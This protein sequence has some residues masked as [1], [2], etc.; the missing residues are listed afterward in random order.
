MLESRDS[1]DGSVTRRRR[2]C[3][4]CRKRFTTYE[5]VEVIDLKVVKKNGHKEE[6]DREKILNGLELSCEKRDLDEEHIE[7]NY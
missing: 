5:R 1:E 4:K 6:F 2:K 3:T 7:K